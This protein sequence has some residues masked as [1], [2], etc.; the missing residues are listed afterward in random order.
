MTKKYK[1]DIQMHKSRKVKAFLSSNLNLVI[2]A[3]GFFGICCILYAWGLPPFTSRTVRTD[4]AYIKGYVTTLAPQVAGNV[5]QVTVKDYQKVKKGEVLVQI[6][7]RIYRQRFAQAQAALNIKKSS[8]DDSFQQEKMAEA[9]IAGA[10]AGLDKAQADWKRVQPL[11]EQGYQSKSQSDAIRANYD[12]AQANYDV[13]L[14]KLQ[15]VLT[16]REAKAADLQGAQ[17]AMALA[18]LDLD[19]TR[20]TSPANGRLGEVGVRVGQYVAPGTLLLSVVPHEIWI[21]ANYKETQLANMMIG[22]PVSFTVDAL[23]HK[24]MTGRVE[25]FAPASGT[26]FSVLKPDNATGNFTKVVQRIPV[27]IHIDENQEG[28]DRLIPGMSVV[29]YVNT[30]KTGTAQLSGNRPENW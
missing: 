19:N 13:A 18:Q 23:R 1:T 27:R 6:D 15:S 21:T 14:Q 25:R 8:L 30:R 3:I 29:V 9:E 2:I 11:M 16:G 28:L 20:I 12:K 24:R 22:Q 7:D 17:A 4:N 5:V 26:E 10:K